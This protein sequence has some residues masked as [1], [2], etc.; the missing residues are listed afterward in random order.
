MS[1]AEHVS[2]AGL[3]DRSRELIVNAWDRDEK[4]EYLLVHPAIYDAVLRAKAR[5]HG[6]GRPIRL[7]GLLVVSSPEVEIENPRVA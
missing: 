4:P 3:L 2:I 7:L 5:E 6:F 1:V